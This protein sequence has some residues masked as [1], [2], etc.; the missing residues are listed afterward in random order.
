MKSKLVIFF[1]IIL[2]FAPT[3]PYAQQSEPNGKLIF[4]VERTGASGFV[5]P[6]GAPITFEKT[7]IFYYVETTPGTG[8]AI[9]TG[10]HFAN[11]EITDV[12][13]EGSSESEELLN[14]LR[15]LPIKS[16]D[17]KAAVAETIS[18]LQ[19]QA[20]QEGRS[21]SGSGIRDGSEYRISYDF[22]G[23]QISYSA[24]NPL[25]TIE[26]L[27]P[28]NTDIANLKELIDLF[29]LQYG[30]RLFGS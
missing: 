20:Q 10:Y 25:N 12:A 28:H 4:S 18:A 21:Y 6:D 14:H 19:Q 1:L 5:R 8:G 26:Y 7:G 16:F 23:V 17:V 2:A 22:N 3:S 29:A 24:W 15:S 11:G 13:G 30:K 9:V 27:A